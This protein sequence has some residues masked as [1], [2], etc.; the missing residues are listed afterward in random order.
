MIH[1]IWLFI[2]IFVLFVRSQLKPRLL[3]FRLFT[4][5]VLFMVFGGYMAYS[6][7]VQQGEGVLLLLGAFMGAAIG[8]IQGRLVLVYEYQSRWWVQG[9]WR[10]ILILLM[11]ALL[12]FVI[13]SAAV[14]AFD[15]PIELKGSQAFVPYVIS[16]AAILLGRSTMIAIR[17]PLQMESSL[18]GIAF[19]NPII[20]K[21]EVQ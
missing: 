19:V 4:L 5:P 17:Y 13:Q 8:L 9:S 18:Q 14:L 6:A 3:S 16:L 12:K 21:E 10:G 20:T 15:I 2:A 11:Y 7:H 1:S